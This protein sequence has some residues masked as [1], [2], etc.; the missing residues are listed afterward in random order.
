MSL[1]GKPAP[2][3]SATAVID[4]GEFE[5]NFSL[6]QFIGKKFVVFFFFLLVRVLV[7]PL[8]GLDLKDTRRRLLIPL[9]D[10]PVRLR[11]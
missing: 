5:E 2:K 3:F 8:L 1:V 7:P 6:E 11:L 9:V 10:F 4:G